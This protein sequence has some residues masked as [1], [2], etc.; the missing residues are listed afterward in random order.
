[1]DDKK[2]NVI[3]MT[4]LVILIIASIFVIFYFKG[5][6]NPEE[7]LMKCIAEKSQIYVSRTCS[8]CAEQKI[9]LGDYVGLFNMTDCL[10]ES[11]KCAALGIPGYPTWIINNQTY[12]GVQDIDELKEKTGC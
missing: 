7:D 1:M 4:L 11:E 3:I 12:F 6:I 8:H 5:Q 9:I 10:E 2:R